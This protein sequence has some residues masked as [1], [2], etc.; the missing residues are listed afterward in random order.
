[1][2]TFL[3][4]KID[5]YFFSSIFSEIYKSLYHFFKLI[6]CSF[7]ELYIITYMVVF[8]CERVLS[9]ENTLCLITP[10]SCQWDRKTDPLM[11][12]MEPLS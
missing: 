5:K 7:F 12:I 8:S 6:S 1:M 9:V 11:A 2:E 4:S 3:G 10:Y